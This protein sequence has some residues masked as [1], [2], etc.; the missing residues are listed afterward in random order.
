MTAND[1]K[2]W[3]PKRYR[4]TVYEGKEVK[5]WGTGPKPHKKHLGDIRHDDSV[6]FFFARG[7]SRTCKEPGIY[8]CGRITRYYPDENQICFKP[9]SPSDKL[10][11][12]PAWDVVIEKLVNE[13]RGKSKRATMFAIL[14]N[15][16]TVLR[17]RV[18]RHVA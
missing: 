5:W 14:P 17:A 6:I 10:K 15:E 13:I 12:C 1:L 3:S 8:G 16:L 9:S 7:S 11:S 4:Q 18:A 2:P